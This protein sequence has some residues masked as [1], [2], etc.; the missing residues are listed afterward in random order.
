MRQSRGQEIG[1]GESRPQGPSLIMT[2]S[3]KKLKALESR[4]IKRVFP[5]R[6]VVRL[7]PIVFVLTYIQVLFEVVITTDS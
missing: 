3:V 6:R 2:A 5:R 7:R 1:E 4:L